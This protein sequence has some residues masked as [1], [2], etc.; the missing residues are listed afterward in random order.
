MERN[1]D[2]IQVSPVRWNIFF[3]HLVKNFL[4][5]SSLQKFW[6]KL[7]VFYHKHKISKYLGNGMLAA[8]FHMRLTLLI[9]KMK[10]QTHEALKSLPNPNP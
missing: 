1:I 3:P 4:V 8:S 9:Y 2:T 7:A 6:T 5:A 10:T